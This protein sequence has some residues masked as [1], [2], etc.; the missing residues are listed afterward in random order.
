MLAKKKGQISARV[1]KS[2]VEK[3]SASNQIP[4][5]PISAAS[6]DF[7]TPPVNQDGLSTLVSESTILPQCIRAYKNNIAGF[8]IGIRY[9]TDT[10][11]ETEEMKAEKARAE[12]IIELMNLDQ[13]TKEVFEN[14]IVARETF[15]IAYLEILRNL[16]NEIVG[17][18]FM[19]S[20]AAIRKTTPLSPYVDTT[21]TLRGQ[22]Y[23]RPKKFKK[24][25][26]Q[27]NGATVYFKEIGDP[28][29]MD[30]HTGEYRET[31]QPAT[32]LL[33][34]AL[35]VAPY[36]E[37]RWLG[38]VLGV[39]GAR[40]AESL[41]NRYF[42]N[43]RHTPMM[44][45]VNG[46]T[47]TD[48]SFEKLQGYMSAI[49]GENGQHAFVVLEAAE[50]AGKTAIDGDIPPTVTIHSMADMLQRDELFQNYLDNARRKAQ[51]AFQ[52]P[53]L[54]VSY[55]TDFN[56]ATAQVAQELTE[57]Q[58]FQPERT[59]LA[60]VINNKL[61]AEYQF[62][63]V[64]AYFLG[65]DISNVDDIVK[66]L[67]VARVAGGLTPN[68]AKE[69]AYLAMGEKA[70]R[71]EGDWGDIPIEIQRLKHAKSTDNDALDSQLSLQITKAVEHGDEN[72]ACVLKEIRDL[73]Q[74]EEC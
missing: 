36:G 4:K 5:E 12:D 62:R 73:L 34:F 29:V 71:F 49:K 2:T 26:Q 44:I 1:I 13:D 15:G 58:V 39:E 74:E 57:Q 18:E 32:E 24:Y 14:V 53:D 9:T 21:Y 50:I 64:E 61:L 48:A 52:L 35:G 28:R 33:E 16:A 41:N 10:D 22:V 63:H 56:R 11:A 37:V 40:S 7:L 42:K 23:E 70:E 59:S 47:L 65:P 72:I 54:Y 31:A 69:V 8:G 6:Y 55:T 38:Q 20:T 27:S 60:W 51:S 67:N 46:G 45:M 19:R 68:K 43:G 66:L 17:I 3:P 25:R 30:R